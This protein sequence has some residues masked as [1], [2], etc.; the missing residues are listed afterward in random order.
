MK[1]PASPTRSSRLLGVSAVLLL[2]L[3]ASFAGSARP[4][5]AAAASPQA[6]SGK[7]LTL[8]VDLHSL[9]DPR[10]VRYRVEAARVMLDG[11]PGSSDYVPD[12]GTMVWRDSPRAR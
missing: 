3:S 2:V 5:R 8:A 7:Y 12:K 1:L 4:A 10:I 11:T 6:M 9:G